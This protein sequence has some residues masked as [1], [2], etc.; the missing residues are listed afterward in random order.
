[1]IDTLNQLQRDFLAEFFRRDNDFFLTGGAA[2]GP[3][4]IS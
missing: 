4:R 2:L 1:M 3:A